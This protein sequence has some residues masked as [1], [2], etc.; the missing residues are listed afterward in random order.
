L[1][2]LLLDQGL[3]RSTAALLNG[4]GWDVIDVGEIGMSTVSDK[5]ILAYAR[6]RRRVC[7][8]LDADFHAELAITNARRPSVI[9]ID[10]RA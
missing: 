10:R 8:T 1:I 5:K 4:A 2:R 9:R 3:P 7:V 6:R